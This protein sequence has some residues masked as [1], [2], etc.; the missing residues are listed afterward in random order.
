MLKTEP[1]CSKSAV[2]RPIQ[3]GVIGEDLNAGADNEHY[4]KHV[5]KV[6]QP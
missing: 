2:S 3:A 4:K 1:L 5:Q 6:L